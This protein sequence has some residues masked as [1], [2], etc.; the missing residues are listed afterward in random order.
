M[1]TRV[2]KLLERACVLHQSQ[3]DDPFG[4]YAEN[5]DLINPDTFVSD[6]DDAAIKKKYGIPDGGDTMCRKI[7][8]D[9]RG[10][11]RVIRGCAWEEYTRLGEK[12]SQ[13]N[14]CYKTVMEEYNTYVCTCDN[15]EGCNGAKITQVSTLL[16]VALPLITFGIFHQ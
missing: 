2:E 7:Y 10:D 13:K 9:V 3:C 4:H 15:E 16:M 11:I 1:A 8:Q 14:I 5:G 6:C 12:E